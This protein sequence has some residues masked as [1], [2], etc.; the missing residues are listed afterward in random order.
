MGDLT[1]AAGNA[2][3][4][5][6]IWWVT[7]GIF[8]TAWPFLFDSVVGLPLPA[9]IAVAIAILAPLSLMLGVPFAYGIRLLNQRNP[10][11]IPWAWAVN[12][13]FSVVGSILTVV[14]SMTLG[15]SAT[16]VMAT[17]IYLIAFAALRRA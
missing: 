15:F 8:L 10:E 13:C 5:A 3:T 9:R 2:V 17:L 7:V 1:I 6:T 4:P 11:I 16:L 14:A 12:G